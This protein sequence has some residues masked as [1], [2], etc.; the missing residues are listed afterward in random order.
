[1]GS[2]WEGLGMPWYKSC[3]GS[4]SGYAPACRRTRP[5]SSR[6]GAR[7]VAECWWWKR[8]PSFD[9]RGVHHSG[10]GVRRTIIALE[11]WRHPSK[12]KENMVH[13]CPY[14]IADHFGL[15]WG[16]A[17]TGGHLYSFF[18]APAALGRRF[19]LKANHPVALLAEVCD[20]LWKVWSLFDFE[21]GVRFHLPST[22]NVPQA[23]NPKGTKGIVMYTISKVYLYQ[24]PTVMWVVSFT[25]P[26]HTA[27]PCPP[28]RHP[29]AT[30]VARQIPRGYGGREEAG[31]SRAEAATATFAV[32]H[33]S[34]FIPVFA[35]MSLGVWPV[36]FSAVIHFLRH[37]VRDFGHSLCWRGQVVLLVEVV[38]SRHHTQWAWSPKQHAL[39]NIVQNIIFIL[40]QKLFWNSV[41]GEGSCIHWPLKSPRCVL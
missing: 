6:M 14:P 1:M 3:A 35:R 29:N 11:S 10:F 41:C 17:L 7:K 4:F 12:V 23:P 9:G 36:S 5:S 39:K 40:L 16:R 34:V 26:K 37:A 21:P 15:T 18:L 28:K 32:A 20:C 24:H 19:L 33:E 22:D 2:S 25:S 38:R 31:R 13:K 27:C 30:L 8:C